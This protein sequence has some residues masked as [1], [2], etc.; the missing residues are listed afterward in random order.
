MND[1]LINDLIECTDS[2]AVEMEPV[3]FPN[4]KKKKKIE[5]DLVVPV[6]DG[7]VKEHAS[8]VHKSFIALLNGVLESKSYAHVD[9]IANRWKALFGATAIVTPKTV[10]ICQESRKKDVRKIAYTLKSR[11]S[12]Y[13]SSQMIESAILD[14]E[15]HTAPVFEKCS[16]IYGTKIVSNY[17]GC[18]L[19]MEATVDKEGNFFT[20]ILVD[21][22]SED[23]LER[24]TEIPTIRKYVNALLPIN[25]TFENATLRA[26][27][28][29]IKDIE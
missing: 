22:K 6:T 28:D 12:D 8:S 19:T 10:A 13:G 29:T 3:H 27:R 18:K 16:F 11:Y 21:K 2:G 24:V 26:L 20:S 25:V 23:L 14:N 1:N 7:E 9:T 4:S 15:V 5:T 17:K